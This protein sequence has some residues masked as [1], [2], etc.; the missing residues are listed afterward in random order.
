MIQLCK[1]GQGSR[2]MF[3][4][5]LC[6]NPQSISSCG[7]P[8]HKTDALDFSIWHYAKNSE[9]VK[10]LGWVQAKNRRGISEPKEQTVTPLII[11]MRR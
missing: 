6:K 5:I 1:T 3:I 9:K 4:I 8:L 2:L 11:Y 7:Q 10:S